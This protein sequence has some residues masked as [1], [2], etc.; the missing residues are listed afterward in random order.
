MLRVNGLLRA[1]LKWWKL[2]PCE[3][4]E[5]YRRG[6]INLRGH[7]TLAKRWFAIKFYL[8]LGNWLILDPNA[9]DIQVCDINRVVGAPWSMYQQSLVDIG[10]VV[11]EERIFFKFHPPFFLICIIGQNRQKFKVH[12]KYCHT[13]WNFSFSRYIPIMQIRHILIKDHI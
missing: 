5:P 1:T 7:S 4:Q 10:S 11:S 9:V 12:K 6:F 13:L 2:C 3:S 8:V